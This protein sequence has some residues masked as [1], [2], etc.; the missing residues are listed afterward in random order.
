MPAI[1][2]AHPKL[3]QLRT[4]PWVWSLIFLVL[5]GPLNPAAWFVGLLFDRNFFYAD[6]GMASVI[7]LIPSTVVALVVL[8]N[9][10]RRKVFN[11]ADLWRAGFW[12]LV[13]GIFAG[14][15]G[16]SLMGVVD[17]QISL[18]ELLEFYFTVLLF[19]TLF[20]VIPFFAIVFG[21][22]C[23]LATV[24]L[25]YLC[26]EPIDKA[27]KAPQNTKLPKPPKSL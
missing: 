22:P 25:G 3:R 15:F 26:S 6:L 27:P 11:D 12:G 8:G 21:I 18:V 14:P 10:W 24:A 1:M 4:A 2:P 23:M 17:G 5:A 19:G 16:I 13:L 20:P 7:V 9:I